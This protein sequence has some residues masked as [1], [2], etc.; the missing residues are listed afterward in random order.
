M[1]RRH[2]KPVHLLL[3]VSLLALVGFSGCG[4]SGNETQVSEGEP[5]KLGSLEFNVQLTR[6]LNP[7][8]PEDSTYLKGAPPIGRGEQY[9]AVFMQ[10]KNVGDAANVVPFPFKII[11][12]RGNIYLSS[13]YTNPFALVSGTPVEPGMTIPGPETVAR[14]APAEGS[15]ILF[16]LPDAAAENRP[17]QLQIPGA[18]EPGLVELDL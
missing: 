13:P 5:L 8:S 15:L 14:N 7:D 2:A 3:A 10:I 18:G 16:R 9:L 12:T 4:S 17:L 11:D 1:R 6:T